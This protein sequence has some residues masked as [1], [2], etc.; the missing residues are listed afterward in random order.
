MKKLYLVATMAL[1]SLFANAQQKV[2]LSTY[3]GTDLQKYAGTVCDVTAYRALYTGW[4]TISLPFSLTEAEL[5]ETFG[6]DCRLEKLVG[7]ESAYGIL[8]LN[9][10]DCKAE[11]LQANVP[12]I[13]HYNGDMGTKKIAKQTML[14][15]GNSEIT[16]TVDGAVVT[17]RGL[18]KKTDTAGLYGILAKDNAEAQFVTVG[19]IA[20][21][22]NATRCCV[23]VSNTTSTTLRT[24][25]LTA[26]EVTSIDK[27]AKPGE[28]VEVHN[29]AGIKVADNINNLQ[30]GI[31]IVKGRKVL[32]K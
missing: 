32:V 22:F 30:P 17:M 7:V 6:A 14:Q 8:T 9:F 13:L 10:Q 27:V 11:G 4:N 24:N 16:F 18:D 21:G 23:S 31:Y 25:H 5:N 29:L 3:T 15:K 28:K 12:Y 1:V 20:N 2:I 19:N 26:G